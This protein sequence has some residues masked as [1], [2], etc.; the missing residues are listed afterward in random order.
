[1]GTFIIIILTIIITAV[2]TFLSTRSLYTHLFVD[3]YRT[4]IDH[5]SIESDSKEAAEQMYKTL[6]RKH[7]AIYKIDRTIIPDYVSK[8]FD[9]GERV[10][11]EFFFQDYYRLARWLGYDL[12]LT[13][14]PLS[15]PPQLGKATPHNIRK[16]LVAC[17]DA[18]GRLMEQDKK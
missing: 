4:A 18:E 10:S 12:T 14:R 7:D 8:A 9:W 5:T 11:T 2:V 15:A 16:E 3:W 13:K 17:W 6:V 1:M